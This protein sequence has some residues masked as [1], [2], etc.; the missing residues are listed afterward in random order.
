MRKLTLLLALL[1]APV[2]S[3]AQ[4]VTADYFNA[5]DTAAT[6]H[7]SGNFLVDGFLGAGTTTQYASNIPWEFLR[8]TN[9]GGAQLALTLYENS[10]V[11]LGG[12]LVRSARGTA[13]SPAALHIGDTLGRLSFSGFD[14]TSFPLASSA[15]IGAIAESNWTASDRS[16]K[17]VFAT[18]APGTTTRVTNMTLTGNGDLFVVGSISNSG[19]ISTHGIH[20]DEGITVLP[21]GNLLVGT[22]TTFAALTLDG[23]M[24]ISGGLGVATTSITSRLGV[25]GGIY[26][27]RDIQTEANL[28]VGVGSPTAALDI[29]KSG[30]TTIRLDSGSASQGACIVMKDW[31]AGGYTYLTTYRGTLIATTTSCD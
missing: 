25:E 26:A 16:A 27:T 15:F 22:T 2:I 21:G 14:G 9:G 5:T 4:A 17:I 8:Q 12:Y 24:Y 10:G 28:G 23:D 11:P 18:T 1:C 31:D 3:S 20:A 19:D 6:S 30:T 13:A 7:F 29:M